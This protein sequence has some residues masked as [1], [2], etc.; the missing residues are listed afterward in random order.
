[1]SDFEA[2]AKRCE[3]A[4]GPDR[5]LDLEKADCFQ[6]MRGTT[7][8]HSCPSAETPARSRKRSKRRHVYY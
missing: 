7:C 6:K 4:T 1:M 8:K 3:E 5:E 2:L